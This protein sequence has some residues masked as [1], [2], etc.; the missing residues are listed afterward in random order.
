MRIMLT[1][2][3]WAMVAAGASAQQAPEIPRTLTGKKQEVPMRKLFL[4]QPAEKVINR[5]AMANPQCV[6]WYEEQARRAASV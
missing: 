6:A 3:L 4:G 2:L 5:D 1:S